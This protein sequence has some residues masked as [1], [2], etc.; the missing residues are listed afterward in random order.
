MGKPE[1]KVVKDAGGI[2][3][4]APPQHLGPRGRK[5]WNEHIEDLRRLDLLDQIDLSLIEV[6]AEV[7]EAGKSAWDSLQEYGE[8]LPD[9]DGSMKK[10]PAGSKHIEYAREY[11]MYAKEIARLKAM[12]RPR[13][14][15]DD[16]PFNF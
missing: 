13:A 3:P 15:D 2:D 5:K 7:Y 8:L 4:Y 10:N 16:D 12:A 14:K 9:R 6:A 11:R 1:L